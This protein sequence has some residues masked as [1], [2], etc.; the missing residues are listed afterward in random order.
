MSIDEACPDEKDSLLA[1][2]N[3]KQYGNVIVEIV[4]GKNT[5]LA[6]KVYSLLRMIDIHSD[7]FF[8]R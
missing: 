3:S 6:A 4:I 1:S 8:L 5:I 7:A 2:Q